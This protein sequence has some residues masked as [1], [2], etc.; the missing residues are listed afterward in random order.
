M[1]AL[2]HHQVSKPEEFLAIVQ[3]GATFPEGFKV[4]AFLPSASH[5]TATC[6][7][8][9]PD[10]T[11]LENLIEPILGATCVNT[12]VQVDEGIAVGLPKMEEP[13]M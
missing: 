7:W 6:I 1:Y 13:V 8:E 11:A 2:V 10:L 9:A 3:S 12:Y 4:I 5:S